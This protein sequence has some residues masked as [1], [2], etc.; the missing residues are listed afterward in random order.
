MASTWS[1]GNSAELL[2]TGRTRAAR[3]RTDEATEEMR[4]LRQIVVVVPKE[5]HARATDAT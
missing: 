5:N 1:V 4:A 3:E 2:A